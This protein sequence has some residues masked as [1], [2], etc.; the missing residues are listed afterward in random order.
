MTKNKL[1]APVVKWVG[2]K[3]QILGEIEKYVPKKFGTYYEPFI[4]GG[5]VLFELQ[6]IRAVVSDINA[7]LIN[8]YEV[9][10]D[11]PDALVEDLKQHKN[12]AEYFYEVREKDRDK[13]LYAKLT[14]VQRA[15]RLLFLNKTC[16]NGLFRVNRAGEF[17]TPFG[18]Y[19]NPNIINEVTLRAVSSYLRSAQVS[20]LCLDF[21]TT[22]LSAS[23]DDFVY[24]DPPYDPVSDTSSFTGY[25]KGGFNQEEQK[26]L[27]L[28]CNDLHARGVKFLL[29]N[30]STSFIRELYAEF[31]VEVVQ[32][33]RA[34]NSKADRRGEVDEVLVRNYGVGY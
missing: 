18:N 33:K 27:K 22:L 7:E 23:K 11:E 32:A 10:R 6:P 3:R 1:V 26:R 15:S 12:S 28:L 17:N 14:P 2:G 8:L 19:K 31:R 5:A 30:S 9:I 34:I 25:D 29:S 20:F 16:F 21:A 24:L 13:A 4:G